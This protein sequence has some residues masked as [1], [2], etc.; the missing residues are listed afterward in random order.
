MKLLYSLLLLLLL[1]ATCLAQELYLELEALQFLNDTII[2]G[3]ASSRTRISFNKTVSNVYYW[4]D[5]GSFGT[6][7]GSNWSDKAPKASVETYC[8]L[9]LS[10]N[11]SRVILTGTIISIRVVDGNKIESG[12]RE[13]ID[14]PVIINQTI[15]V[16]GTTLPSGR[17]VV[18]RTTISDAVPSHSSSC[19]INQLKLITINHHEDKVYNLVQNGRELSP[20]SSSIATEFSIPVDS[21]VWQHMK[22]ETDIGF[23]P[24]IEDIRSAMTSTMTIIRRYAIDTLHYGDAFVSDVRYE[25][26]YSKTLRFFPGRILK[27]VIP[28][29]TPSI[30][31][32]NIQ[33]TLIVNPGSE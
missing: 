7:G 24:S 30:H 19:E 31:G 23:S 17:R 5:D 10:G 2:D 29:D 27:I 11:P 16:H 32:F 14:T 1:G 21:L 33:D 8:H 22:Y 4:S 20:A 25:S 28:P 18:L 9:T 12:F 13:N 15:D 26:T 6:F 3:H